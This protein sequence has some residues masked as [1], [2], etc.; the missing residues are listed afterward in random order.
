MKIGLSLKSTNF[1][2]FELEL[3]S[4]KDSLAKVSEIRRA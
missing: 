2:T 1:L 3:F 4:Q